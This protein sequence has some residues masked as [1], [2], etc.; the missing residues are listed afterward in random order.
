MTERETAFRKQ[1]DGQGTSTAQEIIPAAPEK[2]SL[3]TLENWLFGAANI[4]RGPVDQ[5]DYKTYIFP[6]LFF[7]RICDVYNEEYQQALEEAGGNKEEAEFR[8]NFHFFIPDHCRWNDVREE[9]EN[10]GQALSDAMRCIETANK[11]T[12]YEIFGDAQWTN[13]ELFSDTLLVDLI[14]HFSEHDLSNRNVEPDL[15]GQAYEYLI[16]KFA[17]LSNK[18]AGEFYTPRPVIRLMTMIL[19]PQDSETVYDPACGTGGMLLEAFNYVREHKGEY[20][21]LRLFGQEKNLTTSS[22]ARMNLILHGLEDFQ[23]IRDDTLRRPAFFDDN[24]IR[25]F[26]CVIANPPFSLKKWG[27]EVWENDPY[28]RNFAGMP[29]ASYGDYAWVQHMI[30]SMAKPYGRMAIVLPQGA[31]FRKGAEGKIRTKLL[32]SDLLEAVIGL[33]P[34]LFYGTT[35]AACVCIFRLTK[36]ARHKGRVLFIDASGLFKKGKNQNELL[37]EHVDQIY[38]WYGANETRTGISRVATLDDIRSQ[39]YNLNIS[40]YVEPVIVEDTMTVSEALID[41]KK[42]AADCESAENRLKQLLSETGVL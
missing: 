41:L 9:T 7:K 11:G 25:T 8:E 18:K 15:A 21:R 4:L 6:L 16:K 14:E 42:A 32:D 26:D 19:K 29:P 36:D 34:N 12:L 17:D 5:A 13:K 35:L 27:E 22:I 20:R 37:P 30:A 24:K 23:V 38:S 40:L 39:D 10:V 2:L 28:G 31:L 1:P 33:G 3:S